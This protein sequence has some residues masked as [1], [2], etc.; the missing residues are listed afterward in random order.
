VVKELKLRMKERGDT[1]QIRRTEELQ[2]R[3]HNV[4]Q[5]VLQ[6][7]AQLKAIAEHLHAPVIET[8]SRS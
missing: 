8:M 1:G 6:N 3:I 7:S 2:E 5:I 4:E